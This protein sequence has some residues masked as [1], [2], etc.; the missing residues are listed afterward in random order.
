MKLNSYILISMM[1]SLTLQDLLL[2]INYLKQLK[3]LKKLNFNEMKFLETKYL[4]T[5]SLIEKKIEV[6]DVNI[7]ELPGI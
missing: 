3:N 2:K 5:H 7:D 6:N 1:S 4:Q